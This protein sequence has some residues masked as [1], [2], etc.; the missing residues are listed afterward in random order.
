MDAKDEI[1][2]VLEFWKYK[3][4]NNLCTPEEIDSV[5]KMF[6]ENLDM[7]GTVEEFA[8]FFD[9]S[10]TQIRSTINRRMTDKPKR[11]VYY[12]FLPFLKIIPDSWREKRRK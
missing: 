1:L 4:K 5:S 2:E 6:Q 10:E 8:K 11:R 12:R 7:Y 9:V 3:L